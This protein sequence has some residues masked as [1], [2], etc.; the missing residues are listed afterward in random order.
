MEYENNADNKAS[1]YTKGVFQEIYNLHSGVTVNSYIRK[2]LQKLHNLGDDSLEAAV[3]SYVKEAFQG[4]Y[5]LRDDSLEAK[6]TVI[7]YIET[8]LQEMYN[9][10]YDPLVAIVNSYIREALQEIYNLGNGFIVQLDKPLLAL[11]FLAKINYLGN[12]EIQTEEDRRTPAK[13][14]ILTFFLELE[15]NLIFLGENKIEEEILDWGLQYS[16]EDFR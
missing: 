13:E 9:L 3:N 2:V 12:D 16:G 10:G 15:K 1:K 6:A 11:K 8:A 5:N 7:G 14:I 4:I